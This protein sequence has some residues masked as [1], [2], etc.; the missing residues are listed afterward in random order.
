MTIT[1][2]NRTPIG[3]RSTTSMTTTTKTTTT[4]TT[5]P[6]THIILTEDDRSNVT[7]MIET[8]QRSMDTET[9][10]TLVQ[11]VVTKLTSTPDSDTAEALRPLLKCLPPAIVARLPDLLQAEGAPAKTVVLSYMGK[12]ILFRMETA[13]A[14]GT[15]FLALTDLE[16]DTV[17]QLRS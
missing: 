6:T 2:T 17:R 10:D 9:S 5:S 12:D 7:R 15:A 1:E 4:T 11:D 14:Y 8:L 16:C 13:I 3:T